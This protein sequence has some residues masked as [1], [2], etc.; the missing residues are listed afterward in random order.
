LAPKQPTGT[1]ATYGQYSYPECLQNQT[2]KK[3]TSARKQQQSAS[4]ANVTDFK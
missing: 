2:V 3:R 1:V 4:A